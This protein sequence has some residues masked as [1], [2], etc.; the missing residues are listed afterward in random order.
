[1]QNDIGCIHFFVVSL[2]DS[3]QRRG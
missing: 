3:L 1:M 2:Q